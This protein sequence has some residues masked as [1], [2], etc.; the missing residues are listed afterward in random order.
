MPRATQ[1]LQTAHRMLL[2]RAERIRDAELRRSFLE[3][4]GAHRAIVQAAGEEQDTDTH[5]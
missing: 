1:V 2:E 4:V 3:D 5:R